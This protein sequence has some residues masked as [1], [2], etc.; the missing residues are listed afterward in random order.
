ML[1]LLMVGLA[2]ACRPGSGRPP[3]SAGL[4]PTSA[5]TAAPSSTPR[6]ST[7]PPGQGNPAPIGQRFE[8][9]VDLT[10]QW[11]PDRGLAPAAAAARAAR[12]EAVQDDLIRALGSHGT[13][14]RRLTATAQL[15][16]SVDAE[17]RS[18]LS[19]SPQVA[20][21]RD[22]VARRPTGGG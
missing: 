18:L 14:V 1:V 16:L 9:I 11:E 22:D 4:P 2:A 7:A 19:R 21:V 10:G 5:A 3:S 15:A 6:G 20:A 12:I 13:L 8:V 17:G